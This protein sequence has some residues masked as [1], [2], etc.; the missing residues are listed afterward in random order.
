MEILYL[1][2]IVVCMSIQNVFSKLYTEKM[3]EKGVYTFSFLLTCA[4]LIFFTVTAKDISFNKDLLLYSVFFAVSYICAMVFVV[5]AMANGSLSITTLIVSYSLMIPTLYGL[6]AL[7]DPVGKGF[8]PG[9]ILLVISLLM[10]NIKKGESNQSNQSIKISFKWVI[11]VALAFFGNGMCSVV[12]K[13][14]QTAFE[15]SCKN[16]F[17]ILSLAIAALILDILSVVREGKDMKVCIKRGA[18]LAAVSGFANGGVNLLVMVL[19]GM[20]PV[21]V[22]FPLISAS[23]ITLTYLVSRFCM[24]EKFT[25]LQNIGFIVGIIS[26]VFLNI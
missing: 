25:K 7:K 17:M 15:G 16:E 5:A 14:Q 8:L 22:M 3:Q 21:S 2:V 13:M 10:M 4:A 26:V 1:C 19:S 12:Q 6:F 24:H 23:S 18:G 20:M 11:Y 9:I